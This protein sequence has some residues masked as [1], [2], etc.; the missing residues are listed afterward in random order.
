V[1]SKA[2]AALLAVSV[3]FIF[4]YTF[5]GTMKIEINRGF[6]ELLRYSKNLAMY[7]AYLFSF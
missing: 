1:G 7:F 2:K 4:P 6:I 5:S 3:I